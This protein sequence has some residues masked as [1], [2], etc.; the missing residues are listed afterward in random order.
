MAH[1]IRNQTLRGVRSSASNEQM[2]RCKDRRH[3]ALPPTAA[4]IAQIATATI[5]NSRYTLRDS[6]TELIPFPSRVLAVALQVRQS[7]VNG[8]APHASGLSDFIYY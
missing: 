3:V 7:A 4:I 1:R 2:R 5:G 6:S 8:T